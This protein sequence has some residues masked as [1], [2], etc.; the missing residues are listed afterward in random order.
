MGALR[1]IPVPLG[2]AAEALP[3]ESA[4]ATSVDAAMAAIP[5][6]A[7]PRDGLTL[8]RAARAGLTARVGPTS[9]LGERREY[10]ERAGG[11]DLA[12]A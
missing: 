11:A 7:A 10:N 4:G 3:D 12:T 8:R 5:A 9:G 2:T 1:T 6:M